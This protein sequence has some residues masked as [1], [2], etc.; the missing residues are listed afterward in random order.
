MSTGYLY[1][2]SNKTIPGIL[3]IGI[4]FESSPLEYV[5]QLNK[6]KIKY[7]TPFTLEF[8]KKIKKPKQHEL[9]LY[10]LL[11]HFT[12]RIQPNKDVFKLNLEEAKMFF[13]LIDGEMWYKT[14][15]KF[16]IVMIISVFMLSFMLYFA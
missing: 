15:Y 12:I 10:A 8:A 13:D 5:K 1:C 6:Q 4:T 3:R 7:V 16:I 14:N 2:I 11:E 9:A